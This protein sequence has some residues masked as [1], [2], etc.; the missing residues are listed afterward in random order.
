MNAL[1]SA[2][3]V[4]VA[5]VSAGIAFYEYRRWNA[6]GVLLV[7]VA[8][9]FSAARVSQFAT[10]DE[11]GIAMG[12]AVDA[13]SFLVQWQQG[14]LHTTGAIFIPIGKLL[15]LVVPGF[16]SA[17]VGLPILKV[18]HWAMSALLLIVLAL[19]AAKLVG[20]HDK[21][22]RNFFV[23]ATVLLLLPVS[24]LA[25]KTFNYDAI[26]LIGAVLACLLMVRAYRERVVR[27]GRK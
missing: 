6:L 17:E 22:G 11:Y 15:G 2:A 26:S 4:L 21:T 1:E 16:A 23:L 10:I 14:P 8:A 25:I 20:D 18:L 7:L 24:S 9:L 12:A 27:L 3:A 5:A 13:P 19:Q